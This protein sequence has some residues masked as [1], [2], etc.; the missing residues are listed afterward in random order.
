M[1]KTDDKKPDRPQ[2][3]DMKMPLVIGAT[4]LGVGV[5]TH[6]LTKKPRTIERTPVEKPRKTEKPRSKFHPDVMK[7]NNKHLVESSMSGCLLKKIKKI[8]DVTF[9][10]DE[11]D[12]IYCSPYATVNKRGEMIGVCKMPMKEEKVCIDGECTFYSM[13][14]YSKLPQKCVN[15][16]R[17]SAETI[18]S[19]T[20]NRGL[21]KY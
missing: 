1:E 8:D 4:A 20:R 15:D 14:D 16:F 11:L 18:L 17:K 6:Y 7:L 21:D 12:S 13:P 10:Q 2:Q 3:N 19:V 5:I 9:S